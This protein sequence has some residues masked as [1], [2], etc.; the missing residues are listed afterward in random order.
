[1]NFLKHPN[2]TRSKSGVFK[3]NPKYV[4]HVS[5]EG[6]SLLNVEPRSTSQA[7]QYSHC[8]AAMNEE[9]S[10]ISKIDTWILVPSFAKYNLIGNK[11]VFKVK[12]H[13]DG[14][15][16]KCKAQLVTKGF[17]QQLFISVWLLLP[18]NNGIFVNLRSIIPFLMGILKKLCL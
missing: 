11:W 1:M 7:L 15:V 5:P 6:A 18:Q 4:Y 10:V 14:T 8:R 2:L 17:H 16:H 9:M 3:P 13:H 12:R